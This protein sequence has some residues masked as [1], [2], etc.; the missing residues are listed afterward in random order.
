MYICIYITKNIYWDVSACYVFVIYYG[1]NVYIY[2]YIYV[3][4]YMYIYIYACAGTSTCWY[5]ILYGFGVTTVFA[6]DMFN[7]LRGL[8][9]R[10]AKRKARE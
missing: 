7:D 9:P 6:V 3:Y 1:M 8:D 2:M 10:V 5:V 4:I